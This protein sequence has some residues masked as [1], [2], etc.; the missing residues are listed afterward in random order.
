M[1]TVST[2][3]LPES[4]ALSLLGG[5]SGR[6]TPARVAVLDVLLAAPSALTHPEIELA[7]RETGHEIDRVTLYRV[8]DWL[9]ERGHAHR[10]EGHDRVWRFNAVAPERRQH[11]HF[12]CERCG[13]VFCLEDVRPALTV[14]LP[15]GF[16]L[17]R[18]DLTLYGAC[19]DCGGTPR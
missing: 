3:Q 19:P 18:A 17:E 13:K 10:I 8:L 7:L 4:P 1:P 5:E 6:I 16:R 11:A 14:T 2:V 15:D 12:K 9:V